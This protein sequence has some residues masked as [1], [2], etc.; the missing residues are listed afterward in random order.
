[1]G[2][3]SSGIKTVANNLAL[4]CSLSRSSGPLQEKRVFFYVAFF[5]GIVPGGNETKYPLPDCL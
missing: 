4:D 3:P 2:Y 5:K 1:V